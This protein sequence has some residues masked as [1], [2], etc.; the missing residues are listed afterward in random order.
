MTTIGRWSD[1]PISV[2]STAHVQLSRQVFPAR[3]TSGELPL[4]VALLCRLA[5]K[6]FRMVR[7]LALAQSNRSV[8]RLS[9]G[10]MESQVE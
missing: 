2:S 1:P 3:V 7:S 9:S 10:C 8:P 4:P 6:S 5:A